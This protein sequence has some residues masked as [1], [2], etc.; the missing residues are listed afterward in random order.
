MFRT[1]AAGYERGLNPSGTREQALLQLREVTTGWK[2]TRNN[3]R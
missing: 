1:V 2:G 3:L